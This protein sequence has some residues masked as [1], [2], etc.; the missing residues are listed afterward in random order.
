MFCIVRCLHN[1]AAD[2]I[3]V[4]SHP[5]KSGLESRLEA[6]IKPTLKSFFKLFFCFPLCML[7]IITRH[8]DGAVFISM[9]KVR[10][11]IKHF[12]KVFFFFLRSTLSVKQA[13]PRKSKICV[14]IH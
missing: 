8:L 10:N 4:T 2:N 14:M 13:A 9:A 1:D 5:I 6:V 11:E 3:V 7:I 12:S